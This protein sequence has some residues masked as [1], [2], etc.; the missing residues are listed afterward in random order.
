MRARSVAG[1]G[2]R[3]MGVGLLVAAALAGLGPGTALAST[4]GS[5]SGPPVQPGLSNSL[6]GVA[7]S[8]CQAWAVG[9]YYN[10]TAT[11][12]LAEHWN[13]TAWTQQSSPSPGSLNNNLN[14]VAAISATNIWAVGQSSDNSAFSPS[15]TLAEHWDGTMWKQVP[16]PNPGGPAGGHALVGVAATSASNVWAVGIYDTGPGAA[17]Q[18]LAEHW[19][20]TAWARVPTPS[21]GGGTR[22]FNYLVGVAAI[23]DSDA[24]A[25]GSYSA[26]NAGSLT[27]IEHWN[28]T[29]WTQV[30]SPSPGGTRFSE[31]S[32]VAA[33]SASNVWAVGE[34][35]NR[36]TFQ[37]QTL[38]EHWN[39]TTWT[40][41]PSPNPSPAPFTNQLAGVA[42]TSA[43]N[44]WVTGDYISS[45]HGHPTRTLLEHW[46]GTAWAQV[47][48]P[49]PSSSYNVL[50]GVAATS[51]SNVWAM[52]FYLT[53]SQAEQAMAFHCC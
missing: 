31:L 7:V 3:A 14:G 20:G 25:V 22:I 26:G 16:T 35:F 45:A 34:Y 18:T 44:I 51:A 23:S 40:Q 11:L 1:R 10:G 46:N 32:G 13:G 43:S 19:T 33:I 53:S 41:V 42:A 30:P 36:A 39:G 15:Q 4:C 5:G 50:D 37:Y 8:S 38:I 17:L 21:P 48:S 52:G 47:P 2:S 29:A 6:G 49:N 28:G 24:W 9:N 27:L 12:T